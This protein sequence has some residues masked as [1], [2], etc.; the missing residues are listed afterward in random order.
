MPEKITHLQIISPQSTQ[1]HGKLAVTDIWE[2]PVDFFNYTARAL[3]LAPAI[4]LY[5]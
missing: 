3:T 1:K 2:K 5:I 4:I